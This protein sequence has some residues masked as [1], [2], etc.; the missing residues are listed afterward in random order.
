MSPDPG[1]DNQNRK[2]NIGGAYR[3]H[4]LLL[5]PQPNQTGDVQLQRMRWKKILDGWKKSARNAN[6][7]LIGDTNL[8]FCKWDLPEPRILNMVNDVKNEMETRGFVQMIQNVTRSWPGQPESLVDQL[9]S[10][11]PGCILTTSNEV[12]GPWDHN[13]IGAVIRTRNRE[14]QEHEVYKRCRKNFNLTRY[15]EKMKN[16][17]WQEFLECK[18]INLLNSYFEEKVGSILEEEAPLKYFQIRRKHLNWLT[19]EMKDDMRKR[20]EEKECC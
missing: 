4:K 20:D 1:Q 18:D 16:I 15:I 7:I 6:C 9:W 8:D 2:I 3:D 11:N 5:Q 19:E 12:R 13:L 14:E 10:N 17:D